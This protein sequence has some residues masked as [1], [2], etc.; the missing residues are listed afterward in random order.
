[1]FGFSFFQG[2]FLNDWKIELMFSRLTALNLFRYYLIKII[3]FY[4]QSSFDTIPTPPTQKF[5]IFRI[6]EL[7]DWTFMLINFKE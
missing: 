5:P 7:V 3:T 2:I 6:L 1:M 4:T